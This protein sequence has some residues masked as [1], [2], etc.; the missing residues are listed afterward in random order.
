MVSH[1]TSASGQGID[2]SL[3]HMMALRQATPFQLINLNSQNKLI[4]AAT[5]KRDNVHIPESQE[6]E[7]GHSGKVALYPSMDVSLPP[8]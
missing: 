7:G 8:N 6:L 3:S 1:G 2:L 5:K 4:A